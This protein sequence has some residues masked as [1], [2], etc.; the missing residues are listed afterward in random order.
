MFFIK[1]HSNPLKFL[2]KSGSILGRM[3][4][5][6]TQKV[7]FYKFFKQFPD[8][9]SARKYFENERWRKTGRYCPHCGSVRTSEVKNEK[10]QPYRC[11]DCRKHFSVR[12]GTVLAESNI[13]LHKWLLAIFL[14]ST[15]L[16]GVS[17]CKL[18][19][20]IDVT[21]K[22]AWF[23][24]HRIR[25]V[26]E[27]QTKARLDSPVEADEAYFGGKAH[28]KHA[29]KRSQV[30]TG[31]ADKTPVVAVK[32]RVTK[33]VKA[34]VTKPV[35]SVNLQRIIEETA[36]RGSIIYT[37]QH[38]GY[39]GLKDKGFKHESVNHGVGEYI[40]GKAHT[41]GIESFWSMLKRGYVG[42]YH[43]MS[44]KHLQRYVDAAV[45]THNGRQEPTM[46][47]ISGVVQG[48]LG[49]KLSYKELTKEMPPE[50]QWVI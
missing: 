35:S 23:L 46:S 10:P 31:G 19:R 2:L 33:K 50:S 48:M 28:A 21:Q 42:V 6:R 29:S 5:K 8:E 1:T 47:N 49:K 18:A 44:E 24:A 12:T 16:K 17:S 26:H 7:S 4:K 15:N 34:R 43:Y 11:K 27:D 9:V 22:T 36:E 25:K 37:D 38:G 41:N 13:P 45:A 40:R 3:K 32:S 39:M 30:M 14:L 20:D